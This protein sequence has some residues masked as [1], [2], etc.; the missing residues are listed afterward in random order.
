MNLNFMYIRSLPTSMSSKF[1]SMNL[2]LTSMKFKFLDSR[3]R[4]AGFGRLRVST[5]S[6]FPYEKREFSEL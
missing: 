4:F 2:Q 3:R 5:K 6:E 1:S